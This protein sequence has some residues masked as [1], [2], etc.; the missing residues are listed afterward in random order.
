[1]VALFVDFGTK[2]LANEQKF[3]H[4]INENPNSPQREKFFFPNLH[5]LHNLNILMD[6][7]LVLSKRSKRG[8]RAFHRA[9]VNKNLPLI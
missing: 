4:N 1:M 6:F 5:K 9:P 3:I 7:Y 8:Q 2:N